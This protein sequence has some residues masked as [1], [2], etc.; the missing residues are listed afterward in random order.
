MSVPE[1]AKSVRCKPTAIPMPA[2]IHKRAAVVKPDT[3]Y[4]ERKIVPAPIKPMPG[5]ICAAIRAGSPIPYCSNELEETSAKRQLP[6]L[7]SAN[8]R[9]LGSFP[10]IS[11]STPISTPRKA[12]VKREM[13]KDDEIIAE[14][15]MAHSIPF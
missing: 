10:A 1:I 3:P 13:L 11:R 5:I 12:A 14:K 6:M 8:V 2:V 7:I 4:L 9:M 15:S